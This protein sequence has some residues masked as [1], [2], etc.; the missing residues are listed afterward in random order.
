MLKWRSGA[1]KSQDTGHYEVFYKEVSNNQTTHHI[2]KSQYQ[3]NTNQPM[4]KVDGLHTG[5]VYSFYVVSR[6]DK[7]SPMSAQ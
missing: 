1:N 4:V 3:I 7:G 2:F 6:N 5:K